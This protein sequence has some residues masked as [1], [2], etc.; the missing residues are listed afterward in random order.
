MDNQ[1]KQVVQE[2]NDLIVQTEWNTQ[3][4]L[5]AL[6]VKELRLVRAQLYQIE[7]KLQK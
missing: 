1:S 6:L 4:A 2:T 3:E 7:Q 5:I